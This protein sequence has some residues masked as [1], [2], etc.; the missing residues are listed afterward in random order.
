M[1]R[2]NYVTYLAALLLVVSLAAWGYQIKAGLVVTNMSNPFNWGLYIAT[3]AFFVG[4][5]AGGLIISSSV[6]LFNVK[7]LKP[8]TRI[9]SLSAFA[10][11][12]GAAAIILPDMGRLDRLY[13]LLL[14]P[15]FSSP[16]VW[17]VVVVN[18]YMLITFLSVYFQLLPD[19]KNEGS[20]LAGWTKKLTKNQ[21]DSLSAKWSKR[22]AIIG[23]PVAILI[24]TVTALI[25]AVQASRSWWNT[26]VLPPDFIAMA[27]AS[28]T[29]LV[30][31][32]ALLVTGK[33]NF[34]KYKSA[35]NTLAHIISG[36]LVV[37]F[38]LVAMDLLLH[39]WWGG[40]GAG[41]LSLVFG[42][43]GYLY[44]VELILPA[45][46]MFYFFTTAGKQSRSSLLTGSILLFIG[47]FVHRMMLMFPAFND[48]P[49][50]FTLPGAHVENWKY[51]ITIG[52]YNPP[53]P[54]FT[55]FWAY[56][57]SG[58][59][60]LVNLLPFALTALIISVA[61]THFNFLPGQE[62]KNHRLGVY[63]NTAT[64]ASIENRT[65]N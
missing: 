36:S 58:I 40:H 53:E 39:S 2:L 57:P 9:A 32:I 50:S 52:N 29:A 49:L 55:D 30:L 44:A 19:W 28:G 42:R 10:S 3:F 33:A 16:L 61:V 54:T 23:L 24:H 22:M 13:N 43:Y 51:P 65:K 18:L 21:V 26:P 34:L 48:I 46:T 20:F 60:I 12:V 14:H 59:E 5:A 1:K 4:I 64:T 8:F 47:V 45:V 31:V 35:F 11:I 17:D 7:Q 37:H 6:Y 41:V 27:I 38:F 62:Q 56:A 15:N 25:F 63:T